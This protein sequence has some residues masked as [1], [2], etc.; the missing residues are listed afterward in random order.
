MNKIKTYKITLEYS[1]LDSENYHPAKWDWFDLIIS[2]PDETMSLVNVEEVQANEGH[3][4]EL[5]EVVK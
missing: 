3:V 1:T 5:C 2:S 4:E